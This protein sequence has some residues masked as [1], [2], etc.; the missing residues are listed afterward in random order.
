[1]KVVSEKKVFEYLDNVRNVLLIEPAYRRQYVPIGLGKISTYLKRKR[2][3]VTYAREA[4]AGKF[5]LVC[6][7]TLFTNDSKI[8]VRTIRNI[9]DSVFLGG[10]PV[11]VGGIFASLMP[12]Y[13]YNETGMPC[14]TGYSK[15]LDAMVPD[16]SIDYGIPERWR[17]TSFTFTT[18]GCI[19]KC[20]YCM[21]WR[22]EPK[23]YIN[24][25][26]KAHI[27]DGKKIA[28]I[29]DNNFL[30]APLKHIREVVD[31]LVEKDKRVIFNNALDVRL[32]DVARADQIA[33]LK[34]QGK[35]MRFAFDHMEEDGYY[36][37]ALELIEARTKIKTFT[38]VMFGFKDKPWD[39][40]YRVRE[41]VKY[42]SVPY[43]IRYRPLDLLTRSNPYV[44]KYWTKQLMKAF[45][46]YCYSY[47]HMRL[48]FEQWAK[49]ENCL[50][51]DDWEAWFK[52]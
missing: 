4:I 28:A 39:A 49:E 3:K 31:F 8:V 9:G 11:L 15:R 30:A 5:D 20:V 22:L 6:V 35:G 42:N 29:S 45:Q 50:G 24:K 36:Q 16:Y 41:C 26:W 47:A 14:F 19:N 48:D 25:N 43:V 7:T 23:F 52:K 21:V 18:R 17:D 32:M 44:G 10:V 51:D 1:M 34:Y 27:V 33:R 40:H 2:A 38:Y 46:M 12:E 13:I 37:R